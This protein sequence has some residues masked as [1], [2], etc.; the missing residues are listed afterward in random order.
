[1]TAP[2]VE[3]RDQEIV[4][5]LAEIHDRLDQLIGLVVLHG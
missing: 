5:L 2:I 3:S 1:M 4:E